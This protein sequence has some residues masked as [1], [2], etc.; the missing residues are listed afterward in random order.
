MAELCHC[1]ALIVELFLVPACGHG[2]LDARVH[3][4]VA[5]LEEEL[6]FFPPLGHVQ[7]AGAGSL[8]LQ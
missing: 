1:D 2:V 3:A 8:V 5:V 4:H 6:P 7:H